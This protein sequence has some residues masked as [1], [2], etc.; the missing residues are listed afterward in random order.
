MV[1]R[2]RRPCKYLTTKR[3]GGR[4]GTGQTCAQ[5]DLTCHYFDASAF[6]AP[7]ITSAATAH[8]GNTGRNQFIG[9]GYFSFNLSVIRDFKLWELGHLPRYG[10]TPSV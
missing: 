4:C 8:F 1:A 5:T 2:K 10:P 9:P 7:L 3:V 6:A